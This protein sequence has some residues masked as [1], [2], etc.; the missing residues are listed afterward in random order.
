M[1]SSGRHIDVFDVRGVNSWCA[2]LSNCTT[3]PERRRSLVPG[4][5]LHTADFNPL[6]LDRHRSLSVCRRSTRVFYLKMGWVQAWLPLLSVMV[7]R[8][9]ISPPLNR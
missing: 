7:A 2:A 5:G 8:T 6:T 3:T 9:Y 1:T 4:R